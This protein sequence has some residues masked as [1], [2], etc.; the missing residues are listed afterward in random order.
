MKVITL[1]TWGG[2]AMQPLM[3]FFRVWRERVDIFCLQEVHDTT[4]AYRDERHPDEWV[5]PDLWHRLRNRLP[6]FVG[7]FA[8]FEDNP[9]RMS[10][11][12]F[13]RS[14]LSVISSSA[15]ELFRPE[16]PIERGSAVI[17][18]RQLHCLVV[19]VDGCR[20]AVVNYHGLWVPSGKGDT[21]ERIEQSCALRE[22]LQSINLP[23]VLC[24]DLN[25][26][27]QTA[28]LAILEQGMRN[29]IREFGIPGTR[30]PLYRYF[31]DPSV[32]HFADYMFVSPRITVNEFRVL[33]D[34]AS[35][36]A[37]LYLDFTV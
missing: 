26:E 35:D 9:N 31:A 12:T 32:S 14:N 25:L 3:H 28:S 17:S 20:V 15:V 16:V 10:V 30:T 19:S 33:P 23:V 29:L 24:G 4:H 21:P 22:F 36:H 37:A 8:R 2:R 7:H 1:N 11:A 13:V 6:E 34:L 5:W 27:P 18:P